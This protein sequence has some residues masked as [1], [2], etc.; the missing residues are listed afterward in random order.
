MYI[1]MHGD[2]KGGYIF[3][4]V[5]KMFFYVCTLLKDH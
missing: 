3:F 1:Y 5:K 4:S 2:E